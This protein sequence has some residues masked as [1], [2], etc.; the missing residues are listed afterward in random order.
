MTHIWFKILANVIVRKV[1][2]NCNILA[3]RSITTKSVPTLLSL[4]YVY[5]VIASIIIFA[6]TFQEFKF[7][8]EQQGTSSVIHLRHFCVW[9]LNITFT[10]ISKQIIYRHF[11]IEYE[12]DRDFATEK[13]NCLWKL[14]DVCVLIRQIDAYWENLYQERR[15][16]SRQKYQRISLACE[17]CLFSRLY[18][19]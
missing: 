7:E 11:F 13:W 19:A 8:K 15:H 17:F 18:D 5:L 6:I 2:C 16:N 3:S 10:W 12:I 4:P 9:I 14:C 1:T